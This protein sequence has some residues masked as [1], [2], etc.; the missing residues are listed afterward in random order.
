MEAIS[1]SRSGRFTSVESTPTPHTR[2]W[3][4]SS[5]GRDARSE[6][7]NSLPRSCRE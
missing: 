6:E 1:A 3:V 5:V 7:K 2:G 4:G